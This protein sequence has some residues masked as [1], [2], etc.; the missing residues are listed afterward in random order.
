MARTEGGVNPEVFL[1]A[2]ERVSRKPRGHV[3]RTA[4]VALSEVLNFGDLAY[5]AY[6]PFAEYFEPEEK[7][8]YWFGRAEVHEPLKL[9]HP[10]EYRKRV[11]EVHRNQQAR[12]Y[13]LLFMWCIVSEAE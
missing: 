4:C 5:E 8:I 3:H 7:R 12:V 11:I 10:K 13:A 2:A 9:T 1:Q 6:V